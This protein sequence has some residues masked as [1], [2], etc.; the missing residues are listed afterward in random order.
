MG[1]RKREIVLIGVVAAFLLTGCGQDSQKEAALDTPKVTSEAASMETDDS[2]EAIYNE[3]ENKVQ[4]QGVLY[5]L[6]EKE[7]TAIAVSYWNL[8]MTEIIF[9]DIFSYKGEEYRVIAIGESAFET[10]TLLEKIKFSDAM[11][12]IENNAFYNCP[13]LSRVE[14]GNGVKSIGDR[15]FGE[16]LKLKE[17]VWGDSLESIGEAAFMYDEA[18]EE[19]MIPKSI[20]SYSPDVFCDCYGLK[21]CVFEEGSVIVGAGM[22]TNCHALEEVIL[23]EG[24]TIIQEEAFWDCSSLKELKLPDTLVTIGNRAFYGVSVQRLAL[25]P[26]VSGNM[27]DILDGA[28]EL[29]ELEVTATQ[30][31]S[32]EDALEG[33]GIKIVLAE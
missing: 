23:P 13:E 30:K 24:M 1:Y 5:D 31:A 9:P 18:L 33:T 21:K 11:E 14:F 19:L 32:C 6:D 29:K 15:S 25:P 8:E 28:F 3:N 2:E 26:F 12:R 16:C 7:R 22:F 17:L 27:A 20:K 10:N 4:F